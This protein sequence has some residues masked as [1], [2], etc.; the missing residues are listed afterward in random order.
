MLAAMKTDLEA[1]FRS[2]REELAGVMR[3]VQRG[4]PADGRA[5][6]RA[7]RELAS[8]AQRTEQV[9]RAHAPPAP[10][11]EPIAADALQAGARLEIAGLSGEAV[12]VQGPDR[13]GQVVVRAGAARVT[14]PLERIRRVLPAASS[15]ASPAA[16][17]IRIDRLPFEARADARCDLRGLRVDEALE[18]AE[19]HLQRM[20]G[21][22]VRKVIFIHGH[23]SGALR[24]AI[25]AWLDEV[26]AVERFD[27]GEPAE[28]G[29]GVTVARLESYSQR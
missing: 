13:R 28:G 27:P 24:E 21:T 5:A 16:A 9:E 6:S 10:R 12:L 29:N 25:R 1:A 22:P 8:I 18:R 19:A 4:G 2:A 26:D 7:Q 3:E 15:D 11:P 17:R 14:L 23:G 20:L